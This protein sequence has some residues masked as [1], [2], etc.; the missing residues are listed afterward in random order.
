MRY[1]PRNASGKNIDSQ[2][3]RDRSDALTGLSEIPSF[4]HHTRNIIHTTKI[5]CTRVFV[6]L[7]CTW[8]FSTL[9][10]SYPALSMLRVLT[11]ILL[12]ILSWTTAREKG[13]HLRER[14]TNS[15]TRSFSVG[16]CVC[17][18]GYCTSTIV[19]LHYEYYK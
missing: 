16:G 17:I 3:T 11:A 10:Y 7:L 1:A 6:Y 15:R 5:Y 4:W 18:C 14:V 12:S 13:S 19:Y 9:Y 2:V 8:S